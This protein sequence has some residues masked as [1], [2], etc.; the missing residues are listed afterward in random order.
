V[1]WVSATDPTLRSRPSAELV[2][3]TSPP[4]RL[5]LSN[6]GNAA[7]NVS[8]ISATAGVAEVDNYVPTLASAATCTI[9]AS[10]TPTGS[11]DVTGTL[12]ISD[13]APGAPQKV[14]LSGT[15]LTNTRLL[16][17]YCVQVDNVCQVSQIPDVC[18]AGQPADHPGQTGCRFP[19]GH[20]VPVDVGRRCGGGRQLPSGFCGIQ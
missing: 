14:T 20:T 16:T 18:P 12:S 11:G 9:S 19:M 5:S 15:G 17:G 4:Q 10:F 13:D 3:M 7:L 2:G 6:Y 8:S 1:A